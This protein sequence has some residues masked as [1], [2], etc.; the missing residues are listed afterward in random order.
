M[1]DDDERECHEN[2]GEVVEAY[3]EYVLERNTGIQINQLDC[4]NVLDKGN[5]HR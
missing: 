5:R 2:S 4:T 3:G 1:C